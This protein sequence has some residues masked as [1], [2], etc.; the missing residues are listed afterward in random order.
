MSSVKVTNIAHPSS[1]SN[2]IVLD[3]SGNTRVGGSIADSAGSNTSTPAEIASGRAK[4]WVRF[5]GTGTPAIDAN[6]NVSSITDHNAGDYTINFTTALPDANYAVTF[7]AVKSNSAARGGTFV[8]LERDSAGGGTA[9][10]A[11]SV[12]INCIEAASSVSNAALL[13]VAIIY[14]AIFR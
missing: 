9:P 2:N 11:G 10:A 7:G 5:N 6:Y 4:A 8:C 3:S 13:D 1:A 12:R 14:V